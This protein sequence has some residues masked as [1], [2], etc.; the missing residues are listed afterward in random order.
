MGGNYLDALGGGGAG[1]GG[2][3]EEEEGGVVA[4]PSDDTNG[5]TEAERVSQDALMT[6]EERRER[7][8]LVRLEEEE[9]ILMEEEERLILQTRTEEAMMRE[10]LKEMAE[11]E[12]ELKDKEREMGAVRTDLAESERDA[13]EKVAAGTE[14][15]M[16]TT[17]EDA[18][19]A[20]A[21]IGILY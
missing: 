2:G 3:E 12:E 13:L 19:E 5:Y 18:L 20:A 21:A 11:L 7:E 17:A 6:E 16:V 10:R 1:G 8:E 9:R 14:S 15:L 4:S